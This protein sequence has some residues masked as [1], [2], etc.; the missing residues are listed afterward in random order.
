MKSGYTEN[1]W[2]I[3]NGNQGTIDVET[4]DPAHNQ[5]VRP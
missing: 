2:Y 1:I 4:L 5:G 3:G